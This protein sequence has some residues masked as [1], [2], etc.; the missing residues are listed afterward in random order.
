MASFLPS[1]ALSSYIEI[2]DLLSYSSPF[3]ISLASSQKAYEQAIHGPVVRRS[4]STIHWIANFSTIV[5]MLK[6]L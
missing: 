2:N 3:V 4:D 6:N 1:D 5:K